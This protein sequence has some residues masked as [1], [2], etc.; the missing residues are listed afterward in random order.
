MA[1]KKASE[2]KGE[3]AV[4]SITDEDGRVHYTARNSPTYDRL[5]EAGGTAE[6]V[7]D[8]TPEAGPDATPD[9]T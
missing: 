7:S 8:E 1:T 5:L 3:S 4:V 2:P 6:D 9:A